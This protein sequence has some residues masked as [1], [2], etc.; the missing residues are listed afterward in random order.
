ML[1]LF[2]AIRFNG[3]Y[4]LLVTLIINGLIMKTSLTFAVALLIAPLSVYAQ[5]GSDFDSARKQFKTQISFSVPAETAPTP[6]AALFQKITY[7]SPTGALVAYLSKPQSNSK[8]HPAIIWITGG[9]CNSIGDVWSKSPASNDQTASAYRDAGI[10]MMFP[11]L[12]GGNS[13]LKKHEGFFGEVDD[14]LAAYDYLSKLPNV[15]SSRIYLGGHSTGGTLALLT[16]EAKNPFR[17]VFAFGPV[18]VVQQYPSE[19]IPV[20]FSKYAENEAKLRS[21]AAWLNSAKGNVFVIE[22]ADQP[23]NSRSI[24]VFRKYSQNPSIHFILVNGKNH[25]SVLAPS[26][27]VIANK[28]LLDDSKSRGI[29]LSDGDLQFR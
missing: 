16:A 23:G 17:A 15:D 13:P 9:D 24:E 7:P 4:L 29:T 8:K 1:V 2:P 5:F 28:I 26:N 19:I 22:G 21:P 12:R 14:I 20:D 18:A 27:K 25:F 3:E 6:P 10:V 11:S